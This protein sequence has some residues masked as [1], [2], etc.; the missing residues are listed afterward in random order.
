MEEADA[1]PVAME[2]EDVK[3]VM[4]KLS[5]PQ[6]EGDLAPGALIPKACGSLQ[7]QISKLQQMLEPSK[8]VE[9]L[10]P[11]QKRILVMYDHG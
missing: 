7:K 1:A 5:F 10:T 4:D 11:L 9:R 3:K 8:S 2:S 6:L